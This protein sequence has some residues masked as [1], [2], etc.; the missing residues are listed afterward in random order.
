MAAPSPSKYEPLPAKPDNLPEANEVIEAGAQLVCRD[1]ESLPVLISS[2]MD[3]EAV[4]VPVGEWRDGFCDCFAHGCCHGHCVTSWCCPLRKWCVRFE[5]HRGFPSPPNLV[6]PAPHPD[7]LPPSDMAP[8]TLHAH[9]PRSRCRAGNH[10]SE[11]DMGRTGLHRN[12]AAGA[13]PIPTDCLSNTLAYHH[14]AVAGRRPSVCWSDVARTQAERICFLVCGRPGQSKPG[15]LGRPSCSFVFL[16]RGRH[17][18]VERAVCKDGIH[19]GIYSCFYALVS[20]GRYGI[21]HFLQ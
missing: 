1:V 10:P 16:F 13:R 11:L 6:D 21:G 8:V 4:P 9:L 12:A 18:V 14:T 3:R 17:F 2:S 20:K 7:L 19:E 15:V 5:E